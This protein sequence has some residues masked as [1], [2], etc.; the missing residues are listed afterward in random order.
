[1][2]QERIHPNMSGQPPVR[3]AT[4]P[5]Q[6]L[7]QGQTVYEN[8]GMRLW[9]GGDGIGVVSF[10]TK[11]H[12]VSDAVLDGLREAIGIAE[13]SFDGL[14]IWQPTDPFSAGVDLTNVLG[15]LQAGDIDAFE[16]MVARFQAVSSRIRHARVPVV[17]ALR[18]LVLGGGC[19][20]QMHSARSVAHAESRIGLVET[21]VGLLPGGGGLKQLAMR[22]ADAAGPDHDLLPILE[23]L[24][25]TVVTARVST[26]AVEAGALGLLRQDDVVVRN[27]HE[28]LPV[29][30]Q[31]V[32]ALAE[33]GYRPPPQGR[34]IRVAGGTGVGALKLRLAGLSADRDMSEYDHEIATRIA[35]VLCGGEVESGALVDEDWLFDLERKH[36]VALASHVKTRARIAHMLSTGNPLRN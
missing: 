36:I 27:L 31:Q 7:D 12:T 22:A 6:A 19:E 1:M 33:G 2:P 14:V 15:W 13:R 34:R 28:L 9:T 18:G 10:T 23:P 20:F 5:D 32:R 17:T 16:A 21:R 24:L 11:M 8:E 29:A 30:R 4:A 25:E 35:T 26:S 3:H